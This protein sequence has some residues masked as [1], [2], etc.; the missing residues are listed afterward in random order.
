MKEEAP[1]F[2]MPND[3]KPKDYPQKFVYSDECPKIPPK[4]KDERLETVE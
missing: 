1:F 4:A 2:D 3:M